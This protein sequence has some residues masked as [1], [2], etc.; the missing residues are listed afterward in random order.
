MIVKHSYAHSKRL[1]LLMLVLLDNVLINVCL[2]NKHFSTL[3]FQALPWLQRFLAQKHIPRFPVV[4]SNLVQYGS[5]KPHVVMSTW[6]VAS[7]DW[8]AGKWENTL[9]IE[10][11]FIRER[12]YRVH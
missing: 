6:N 4:E 1:S 9:D 2:L 12:M 5:Q 11:L 3:K 8:D 7:L 10:D